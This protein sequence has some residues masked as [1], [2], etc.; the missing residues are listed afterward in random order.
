MTRVYTKRRMPKD[1]LLTGVYGVSEEY[2]CQRL[3]KWLDEQ[4]YVFSHLPLSTRTRSYAALGKNKRL[5]VRRG[6]PDYLI[7][8]KRK[9]VMFLEMKK[10]G[11]YVSEDQRDWLEKLSACGVP[12]VVAYG[13]NDAVEKIQG[14]EHVTELSQDL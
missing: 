14:A 1:P 13:F 7:V 12:A 3:V 10:I 8:L 11:G 6:V 9:Q 5:G 4:G 2:E